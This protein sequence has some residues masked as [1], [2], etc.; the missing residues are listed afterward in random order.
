M[1]SMRSDEVESRLHKI[2]Q[3]SWLKSKYSE[4]QSEVPL[5]DAACCENVKVANFISFIL[6]RSK[7]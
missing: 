6:S 2:G 3:C 7:A 4:D 1:K 5:C